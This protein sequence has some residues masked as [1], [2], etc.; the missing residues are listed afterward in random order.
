M[1]KFNRSKISNFSL[2]FSDQTA[3]SLGLHC[4]SR[5]FWQTVFEIFNIYLTDNKYLG[6][7]FLHYKSSYGSA[8]FSLSYSGVADTP[9]HSFVLFADI[10]ER[11]EVALTVAGSVFSLDQLLGVD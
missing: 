11:E 8:H 9:H 10:C 4:L 2:S 1:V 5:P 3:S 7:I 6:K